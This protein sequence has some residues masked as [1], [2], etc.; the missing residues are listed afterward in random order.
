[1][2]MVTSLSNYF[3]KNKDLGLM[4]ASAIALDTTPSLTG[5]KRGPPSEV[6]AASE[7]IGPSSALDMEEIGVLRTAVTRQTGEL[8]TCSAPVR[9]LWNFDLVRQFK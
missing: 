4:T 5:K 8:V 7:S 6:G 2:R 9:V 3:L 1:M